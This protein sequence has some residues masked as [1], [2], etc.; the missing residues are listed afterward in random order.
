VTE[1]A[2]P[3]KFSMIPDPDPGTPAIS[4]EP[5]TLALPPQTSTSAVRILL[6][7]VLCNR[8]RRPFGS[9]NFYEAIERLTG[10]DTRPGKPGRPAKK[11]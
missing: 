7:L 4:Q 8:T 1:P 3:A 6:V 2:V 9:D 5:V 10:F 11:Q